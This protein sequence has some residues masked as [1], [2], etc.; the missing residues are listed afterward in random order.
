[1]NLPLKNAESAA[2]SHAEELTLIFN[3]LSALRRGDASARLPYQGT[4]GFGRVA[5]GIDLENATFDGAAIATP[6]FRVGASGDLTS[7][8]LAT[9]RSAFVCV[10]AGGRLFASAA[11]C[12]G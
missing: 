5:T 3:A 4:P 9:G 1:M 2:V 11:P 10:D 12:S 6:G 8:S 7:A